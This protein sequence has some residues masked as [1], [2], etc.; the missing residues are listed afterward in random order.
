MAKNIVN[1]HRTSSSL[2][3][4]LEDSL[5]FYQILENTKIEIFLSPPEEDSVLNI[6]FLTT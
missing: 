6:S 5:H 2:F 1:A 3:C 4:C